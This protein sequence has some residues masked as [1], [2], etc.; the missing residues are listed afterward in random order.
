MRGKLTYPVSVILVLFV[1]C[2]VFADELTWDNSS[3][4]SLWSNPDNWDLNKVPGEDDAVYI[5]WLRDPTEVI[6]D[7]GTDARFNSVTVSND[8]VGGQ[9]YVHL[10]M[11]GGTLTAGNLIRIAREE[12]GMFTIDDGEVICSALQL[13]RK[14]PSKGIVY[15]NGGTV[16]VETNVRI[17]RGGSQ[18]SKL[19]LIAGELYADGLV[20]NDPEDEL[21]GTNGS[22]DI[23]GGQLILT[24]GED[25]TEKIKGYVQNGWIT[26]F[27]VQSGELL[28]GG[29]L[30]QVNIEYKAQT[31]ITR[32]WATAVGA[33]QARSPQPEDGAVVVI[34]DATSLVWTAGNT[35]VRHDV[36]FDCSFEDV[37]AADI[38]DT[39]GVYR[40]SKDASGYIFPEAPE[41]GATYYWR[42]DEIEADNNLHRG[43][44]WSFTVA[45][46]IV[47]DDFEA[48]NGLDP[49]DP[50]SNRI[51]NTWIDGFS[52]PAN[53][54]VVGYGEPP[55]A[56][57]EIIHGGGRSMP[58]FYNNSDAINYSEATRTLTS[59]RDWTQHGAGVLSLWFKGHAQKVGAFVEAPDG[60]YIMRALGTDIW[61]TSDEFHFAY[62]ELSGA[63]AIAAKVQSLEETEP[64][65]KAGV[66]I[67][68]SLDAD[69]AHVMMAVTAGNG[70]WFG[71]RETA[72]GG[73]FSVKEEGITAPQ[74]VKLERTTGGLVRA[75]Y[76]ADG[77]TWTRLN[78]AS[79]NMT[80]PVYVGLA[81]T[82]NN[83][84]V[85]CE[86][87]FT[88][89][90]FPDTNVEPQW[91]NRDI[92]IIG[93]E[94]EPMYVT[95]SNG[96]VSATVVHPDPDA[97]LTEEWTEWTTDLKGFSDGG[98]N[99]TDVDSISIGLGDKTGTH[100][101]GSGT[102][103]FD[104]IRLYRP[105]EEPEK[106]V[107]IQW[108]GHSTVKVWDEDCIVYVDP[109][110]VNE[111]LHDATLVCVTHT[112][113][114]H[115]SPADIAKVS[116]SQTLFV[117]PPD[118]IRQ[119]GSGLEMAPGQTMEFENVSI[120]G[121][122]SYNINKTNH[123][124]SNN[125]LGYIIEI[126]SKRIYVAGDTDLI[127]EM[128]GLGD[129]DV[130]FLPV[131][132]T[133]TMDAIEAAEATQYI[134]PKLAIPYHWGQNVGSLSD[135]QTFAENARCAVVIPA[136]GETISSD[137]WPEYSPL[138]A[139]WR[140]DEAEGVIAQDEAGDNDGLVFGEPLWR[141]GGGKIGGAL[142]LDG[143]D[144]YVDC[145]FI[146]NPADGVFSVFA[147]IQGGLPGQ[148]I[149]SQADGGGRGDTWIGSDLSKGTLMSGLVPAGAGRN[150]P[151]PLVSE[152]EIT[153][154]DW[155]HVGFVWDGSYRSLF[156]DGIEAAK[157]AQSLNRLNFSDGV[158]YI[159][160]GKTL[161][162]E[163]F[164]F[165]QI[166]DVR[167]YN[168]A[169][170]AEEI[171]SLVE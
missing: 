38:T 48:Y 97:A 72:G 122:A 91:V 29:L 14:E 5:N 101:G 3:G 168:Q 33:V 6:I 83:A 69:S 37:N 10:H 105:A 150:V 25:Q 76:S 87:V 42:V 147:W 59:L 142:K 15:I 52:D 17:P 156:K 43:T 143:L 58:Y 139:H 165:G 111:S 77:V 112:H 85:G 166:D 47:V 159:G 22:M 31:G 21:S 54:S 161:T 18:G 8:S 74:W 158:L 145:G 155:Q 40:G 20:M 64:W 171:M 68:D 45:D 66:M 98:V 154:G 123:P 126:G 28:D 61:G 11:T 79:I 30:A 90:S 106:I 133:Y 89:V 73:S 51:F 119:Y 65:S 78:T 110:R 19:Y 71:Y 120:I 92:G 7:A 128:R 86:A 84:D 67:R 39:T 157:D 107:N 16:T 12:T 70:V 53:G 103:F 100:D 134:R 50:A 99:L 81:L 44:V 136:V 57:Q 124:K 118:V 75:Y 35:A 141:P 4:D 108:L 23:V 140:L 24:S 167:I 80:M 95:L 41:W 138:I 63:V 82:S 88:D 56:E 46:Y 163:S 60:T 121:V 26:A 36:Y 55:F 130:A 127:E 160:A 62:K 144:D 152:I 170:T 137:N 135:A 1:I 49:E 93:N 162:E 151:Q 148:A 109:E 164:F 153:D 9:G 117:G 169:L 13:G 149:V 129:I 104:D 113:S 114:D 34:T 116:N 115:Y 2:N 27:G 132:G 125:W 102:M 131:G 32:V 94:P 146:L 96:G